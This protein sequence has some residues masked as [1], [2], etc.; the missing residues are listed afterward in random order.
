MVIA[1]IFA[2]VEHTTIGQLAFSH[3]GSS[4]IVRESLVLA[5]VSSLSGVLGAIIG[6]ATMRASKA[7]RGIRWLAMGM[8]MTLGAL[9]VCVIVI[10]VVLVEHA[11]GATSSERDI[12]RSIDEM[13]NEA[14]W[15][16]LAF[17]LVG[18]GFLGGLVT[19]LA[20][21][22]R[23]LSIVTLS[24]FLSVFP[25]LVASLTIADAVSGSHVLV[26]FLLACGAAAFGLLGAAAAWVYSQTYG[27]PG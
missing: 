1:S 10:D 4:G 8:F 15:R 9:V 13:S 18:T 12:A 11:L 19:Q 21:G 27:T 3:V 22:V 6:E 26:A 5:G 2:L 20:S 16:I 7:I 17:T 23:M 14:M 25:V 24:V